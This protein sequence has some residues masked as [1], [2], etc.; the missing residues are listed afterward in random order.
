MN[1]IINKIS[2]LFMYCAIFTAHNSYSQEKTQL[3]NKEKSFEKKYNTALAEAKKHFVFSVNFEQERFSI[4]RNKTSLSSGFLTV[5][6]PTS[7]RFEISNP[8][9]EIYISNGQSFWKY[10]PELKHAQHLKANTSELGFIN[11]L[12]N[13]SMIEKY[14][15]ISKW[16]DDEAKKLKQDINTAN[17]KSD[18]PPLQN[19]DE[20][21]LKLVPN[22]D[23]HQKV[24]YAIIKV[25]TGFIRE[26]RIVQ[27]NGNRTRLVFSDYSSKP[28][29][30]KIFQFSPP[31]GIAVDNMQ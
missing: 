7:F 9:Q 3:S 25:K 8:R 14:Y 13:L 26:L 28:V 31:Q 17:V 20:L 16:T 1:K 27:L 21:H 12:T 22:G 15:E 2:I 10:I 30:D 5:K 19:D 23:K 6:K 29:S 18:A 4:L 11:L 24:I